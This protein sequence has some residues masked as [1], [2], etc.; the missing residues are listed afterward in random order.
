ME[1][2]DKGQTKIHKVAI[3]L[4]A[5]M[6]QTGIKVSVHAT[7]GEMLGYT[8]EANDMT[9][10]G[11]AFGVTFV[12]TSADITGLDDEA[13]IEKYCFQRTIEIG[14]Q[15]LTEKATQLL[16]YAPEVQKSRIIVPGR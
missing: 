1:E 11:E 10:Q 4:F 12:I 3:A 6:Q 2:E 15:L 13:A 9:Q 14:L 16:Q 8:F 5:F 7:P